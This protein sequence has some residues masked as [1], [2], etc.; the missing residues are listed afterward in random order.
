MSRAYLCTFTCFTGAQFVCPVYAYTLA[1]AREIAESHM[2]DGDCLTI[3]LPKQ[4]ELH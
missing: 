3:E 2:C 4:K 1:E